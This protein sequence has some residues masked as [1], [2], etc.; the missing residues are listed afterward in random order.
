[1]KPALPTFAAL[2]QRFFTQRLMQQKRVSAHTI[3]SYRDTFRLLLIFAQKRLHTSPDR[4]AFEMI[5]APFISAFLSE[6]EKARSV[7]PRTRN[8]RLTAIRS[9]FRFAAY[10]MPTHSAQIQRILAMPAKR[11][12]R[13]LI[14]FMTRPEVDALLNAPDKS[15]R[16]GRLD[17]ALLLTTVQT[18]L[19]LSE[20]TGLKRQDV[21]FGTGAHVEVLGKGRKHR[22]I[23][24]CKS[25]AAVLEAWLDESSTA[26]DGIVFPSMRGGRLSADAVEKP[27]SRSIFRG[28]IGHEGQAAT[29]LRSAR[30]SSSTEHPFFSWNGALS[31]A[32]KP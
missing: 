24:L 14:D 27:P 2:L 29:N 32:W 4:L 28:P 25:V 1:M 16:N 22:A 15:S 26:Q 20:V 31:V 23:P 6:L 18:G 11:F 9:F 8:L 17:H 12:D 30:S 13:K 19:R 3:S 7:T 21:T 10:E 5:D